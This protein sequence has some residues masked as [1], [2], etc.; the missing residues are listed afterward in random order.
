MKNNKKVNLDIVGDF[1]TMFLE[2]VTFKKRKNGFINILIGNIIIAT[3]SNIKL[4]FIRDTH[5]VKSYV[6][7]KCNEFKN[8]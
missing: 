4:V 5:G 8:K 1:G 2:S 6:V 7:I 3:V